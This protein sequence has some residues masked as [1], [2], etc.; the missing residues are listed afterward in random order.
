M[1]RVK[2]NEVRSFKS[3]NVSPFNP[4]YRY[5]TRARA[6]QE[7]EAR[8]K[9]QGY[10]PRV[11]VAIGPNEEGKYASCPAHLAS[12]FGGETPS[13]HFVKGERVFDLTVP[14]RQGTLVV[15]GPEVCEVRW[16]N[17]TATINMPNYYI[18]RAKA[19]RVERRVYHEPV[20]STQPVRR[21]RP[22]TSKR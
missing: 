17:I 5:P 10:D 6:V 15:A 20:E 11:Y 2:R 18:D 22:I 8:A 14:P 7:I 12:R 9:L 19:K 13:R 21:I 1:Q 3:T 16:D 4:D